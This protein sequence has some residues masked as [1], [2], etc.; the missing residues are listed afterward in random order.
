VRQEW[1][2]CPHCFRA[3][4][5][6]AHRL[7]GETLYAQDAEW[8]ADPQAATSPVR[9]TGI[10]APASEL[11][12]AALEVPAQPAPTPARVVTPTPSQPDGAPE[13]DAGGPVEAP[14]ARSRHRSPIVAVVIGLVLLGGGGGI[15]W[16][17][18]QQAPAASGQILAGDLTATPT[19]TATPTPSDTPTP[20]DTA[21]PTPSATLSPSA[22]PSTTPSPTPSATATRAEPQAVAG[23]RLN[24][25][26]GPSQ[27]Y[28][29]L[30]TYEP[31]AVFTPLGRND[32]GT[33]LQVHAPDGQIG[34]ML[35]QYLQLNVALDDLPVVA[36]PP[37]PTPRP[38]ARPTV[39]PTARPQAPAPQ[40]QPQPTD[41]PQA[42]PTP[43]PPPPAPAPT[44]APTN[45]PQPTDPPRDKPN[46]T[47]K[48]PPPPTR[49]PK[50]TPPRQR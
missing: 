34:W 46:P 22:T 24:M 2:G 11:R 19:D 37:T 1:A 15:I 48:E 31:G 17:S 20:T 40:P 14:R 33:W 32:D 12:L 39:R 23:E 21:T 8:A 45:P 38:T 28:D 9:G 36:A 27:Q 49:Q 10:A 26:S 41:P 13:P 18:Q 16:V 25:R 43:E 42:Q 5:L 50:P 7:G 6:T 29:V 35:A 30:G 44:Q 4:G 47:P 3:R